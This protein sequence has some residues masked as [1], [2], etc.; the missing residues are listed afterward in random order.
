MNLTDRNKEDIILKF[1]KYFEAELDYDLGNFDAGF[2]L[3]FVAEKLGPY[4]YNQG[5]SDARAVLVSKMED[6]E[7]DIMDIEMPIP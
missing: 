6:V 1:Q 7:N 2:L 3:D 4:F 5:L